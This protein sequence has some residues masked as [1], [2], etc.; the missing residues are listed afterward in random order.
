MSRGKKPQREVKYQLAAYL[1]HAGSESGVKR[2]TVISIAEGAGYG[3]LDRV[4]QAFRNICDNHLA[5]P[6]EERHTFL[7]EEMGDDFGFPGSIGIGDGTYVRLA[8]KPWTNGW[9]Y[10]CRKKFYAVSAFALCIL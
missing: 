6:G 8:E 2:A 9:S 10:W 1:I 5:W 4:V 3:Y 7:K